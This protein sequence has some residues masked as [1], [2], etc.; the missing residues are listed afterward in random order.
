[1]KKSDSKV[2]MLAY[3]AFASSKNKVLFAKSTA[4]KKDVTKKSKS[5]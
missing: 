2:S 1:M 3:E 5:Q 4:T